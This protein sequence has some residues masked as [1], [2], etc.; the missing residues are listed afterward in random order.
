LQ[1]GPNKLLNQVKWTLISRTIPRL[2][3]VE[4]DLGG[5]FES[6]YSTRSRPVFHR[7]VENSG[8]MSVTGSQ[9]IAR[10]WARDQVR[11][12]LENNDS[13]NA[14]NLAANYQLVTAV[15]GAVVLESQQQYKENDL[16]PVDQN[17]VPTIPEPH[18]WILAL[19]VVVFILWF[20][21][22]NKSLLIAKA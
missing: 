21:R 9:H 16:T 10:L 14:I 7:T 4:E 6:L 11:S 1:A 19:F 15:S 5:F 8:L 13:I 2:G 18:Q 12:L 3:T 22:Q 17:T 20:L